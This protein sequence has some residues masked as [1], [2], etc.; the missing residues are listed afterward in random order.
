MNDLSKRSV[1][2]GLFSSDSNWTMMT[3]PERARLSEFSKMRVFGISRERL[4]WEPTITFELRRKVALSELMPIKRVFS[5]MSC[6]T[7]SEP[8]TD[9]G[10]ESLKV[11]SFLL[12]VARPWIDSVFPVWFKLGLIFMVSDSLHEFIPVNNPS[13]G[14]TW[15]W[16]LNW[17]NHLFGLITVAVVLDSESLVRI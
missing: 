7:A 16:Y 6:P 1:M 12:S 8:D 10:R 17:K 11:R 14:W 4:S 9:V 3:L 2:T 13:N 5:S 15:G